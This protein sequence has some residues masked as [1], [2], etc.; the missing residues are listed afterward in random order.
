MRRVR[1]QGRQAEDSLHPRRARPR[2]VGHVPVGHGARGRKARELH[3]EAEEV[4]HWT[5]V[6]GLLHKVYKDSKQ[7]SS[8]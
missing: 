1:V 7:V 2:A 4:E 3:V 8:F 6:S 5:H